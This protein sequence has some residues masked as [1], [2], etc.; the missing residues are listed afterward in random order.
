MTIFLRAEENMGGEKKTNGDA[1]QADEEDNR[2]ASIFLPINPL[3]IT[4][5]C[6][7]LSQC[8][9]DRID[10]YPVWLLVSLVVTLC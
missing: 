5:P 2:K 10:L 4:L 7:I 3:K 8:V 1:N 9:G 6:S